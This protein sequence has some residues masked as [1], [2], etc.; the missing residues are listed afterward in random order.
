MLPEIEQATQT[1]KPG[2]IAGPLLCAGGFHIIRLEEV[3]TPV[4]PFEK[5]KDEIT[6]TLYQQKMENSY[7]SWLQTLRSDS[8]IEN[9]L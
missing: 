1:L 9:R 7:R 8:N 4:K 2:D 3:R 5:V 6:K